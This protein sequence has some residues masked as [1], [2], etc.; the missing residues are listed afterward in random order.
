MG[1][2]W[3]DSMKNLPLDG[4]YL[5]KGYWDTWLRRRILFRDNNTCQLCHR[6]LR[7]RQLIVHHIEYEERVNSKN[8]VTLCD[9]CHCV[10]R[11]LSPDEQRKRLVVAS[12]VLKE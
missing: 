7:Q 2:Y 3:G 1:H 5:G 9:K 10:M 4:I 8:L 11:G 12:A 6:Q